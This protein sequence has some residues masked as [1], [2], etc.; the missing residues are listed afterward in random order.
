MSNLFNILPGSEAE[1]AIQEVLRQDVNASNFQT[2]LQTSL[3]DHGVDSLTQTAVSETANQLSA[4]KSDAQLKELV[5]DLVGTAVADPR[6]ASNKAKSLVENAPKMSQA[7]KRQLAVT[8]AGNQAVNAGADRA[9][10]Q[11][12]TQK[13][14]DEGMT[15][16]QA[17]QAGT[18][19]AVAAAVSSGSGASSLI[20]FGHLKA[21]VMSF[22][23]DTYLGT[24][25]KTVDG[26]TH[27]NIVSSF[28]QQTTATLKI[29]CSKYETIATHDTSDVATSKSFYS[30]AYKMTSPHPFSKT[31]G[32]GFSFAGASVNGYYGRW[33]SLAP[34]KIVAPYKDLYLALI[35]G[36]LAEKYVNNPVKSF[37]ERAL[38]RIQMVAYNVFS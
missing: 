34:V 21:M 3:D 36:E 15:P 33:I 23:M 6:L 4:G 5:K 9:L 37:Y 12:E 28:A 19:A 27:W 22:V 14:L 24:E 1:K 32:W 25:N 38:L 7:E 8:T 20:I 35:S 13:A 29:T 16:A 18:A 10:A 2:V 31:T 26:L 11:E 30:F 17:A